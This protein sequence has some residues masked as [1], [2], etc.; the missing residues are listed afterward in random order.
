M[1][2]TAPSGQL[3]AL[4]QALDKGPG[5][6]GYLSML[7]SADIPLVELEPFSSWNERH[8]TRN[9]IVQREAYELLL[10]CFEKGQRTSIHDYNTEEAYVRPMVGA[11]LE[12][13]YEPE[14][15]GGVRQVGSVLLSPESVSHLHDGHSIHRYVNAFPGRSMTLNLYARPLRKWRVYDERTGSSH[16]GPADS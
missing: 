11:V 12:E 1:K 15:Q 14:P 7:R 3:L 5:K 2:G 6:G 9:C 8:Y 13:R 10:I 4:I 16:M